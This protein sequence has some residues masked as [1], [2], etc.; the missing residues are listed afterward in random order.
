MN[1]KRIAMFSASGAVLA[2]MIAGATT[3]A[4]RRQ[5]PVVIP[6]NTTAIELQGAA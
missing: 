3:P 2:A 6:P 5:S 4:V 1:V